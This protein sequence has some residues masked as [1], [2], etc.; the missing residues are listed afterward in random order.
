MKTY[1]IGGNRNTNGGGNNNQSWAMPNIANSN[2]ANLLIG[3]A[4]QQNKQPQ[5]P[6]STTPDS[7]Y[8]YN[9]SANQ[10]RY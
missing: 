1:L 2:V 9:K 4:A 10:R 8:D 5:Q 7:R 3:L 6:H